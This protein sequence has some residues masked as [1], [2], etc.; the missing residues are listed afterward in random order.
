MQYAWDR[1]GTWFQDHAPLDD[2][3]LTQRFK[4][5]LE[6]GS[7]ILDTLEGDLGPYDISDETFVQRSRLVFNRGKFQGH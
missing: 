5:F 2:D 1:I 3:G 6:A 4:R 7:I